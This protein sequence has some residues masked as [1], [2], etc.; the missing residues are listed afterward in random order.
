MFE[1]KGIPIFVDEEQ[2][3]YKIK[4]DVFIQQNRNILN[5]IKR[6]GDNI[7]VCCP[8][9]K[10]G[11][12]KMPSCG[13]SLNRIKDKP[14]GT[15]HC[16]ACGYIDTFEGFINVCF[17]YDS[18]SEFGVNWLMEN[19]IGDVEQG[20]PEIPYDFSRHT[21]SN[22]INNFITEQE[23]ASYRYYHPYMWKRKLTPEIVEKY[24]VGFQAN[25]KAGDNWR[26]M[27]VITFPVRDKN[28]NCLFV[29]RRSVEGKVF[30]LPQLT[31]KPVY[32]IYELP[33]NCSSVIIC[34]SV[35]NALTCV[36]YGRPA[37]A[38]FGTGSSEQY[39]E[40]LSLPVRKFVVALDPDEA[41]NKGTSKL[42]RA[43]RGRIV[44][45]LIVPQGKDINDLSEIE[46]NNLQEIFI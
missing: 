41:G 25:Y 9:H 15:A 40:L 14:P 43:L 17:G 36:R 2:I 31:Y 26:P 10:N 28:G 46:F 12:E 5:K 8:N 32:G 33:S 20:R 7:M 38:L 45:K 30:F 21:I 44:T 13:I 42:K 34:E 16:F 39:S 3:L 6:S 22:N 35:I 37:V 24:D 1:V 29:S 23:L 19:F 4:E 27:D 11:Q 18:K